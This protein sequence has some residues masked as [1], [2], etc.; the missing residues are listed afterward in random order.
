MATTVSILVVAQPNEA[1]RALRA[2]ASARVQPGGPELVLLADESITGVDPDVRVLRAPGAPTAAARNEALAGLRGERV[3][4]VEGHERLTPDALAQHLE[5]LAGAPDAV[6]SY[7]R[8]AVQERDRVQLRPDS[9]RSGRILSRLIHDKH[10]LGAS[11]AALWRREALGAAPFDDGYRSVAATRL[12]MALRVARAG[13]EFVFV[14]AVVAERDAEGQDLEGLEELVRVFL[15]L[16]YGPD[17]LDE[18]A[19]QRARMRLARQLVAIGKHHFRQGDHRRAG[20]FFDEAVKA[21]P[22]YFKGRR[23]QFMNFVARNVLSRNR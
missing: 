22:S 14:P 23:Y 7:G 5:A 17:P 18:K 9:G 12:A 2:L 1:E 15:S 20:K 4:I 6:G 8:T 13:G 11:A 16:L 3:M 10:L 21:A 19:E